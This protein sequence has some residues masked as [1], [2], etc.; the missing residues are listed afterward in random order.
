MRTCPIALYPSL[1]SMPVEGEQRVG[2]TTALSD[3]PIEHE[4]VAI[5]VDDEV[6]G[7]IFCAATVGGGGETM[8]TL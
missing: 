4:T 8:T 6:R 2:K 3:S 7:A 5:V 1:G